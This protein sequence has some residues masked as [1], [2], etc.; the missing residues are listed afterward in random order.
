MGDLKPPP[1][2]YGA[3]LQG[4]PPGATVGRGLSQMPDPLE[5][6]PAGTGLVRADLTGDKFTTDRVPH[7]R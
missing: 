6:D 4:S 3:T 2:E 1:R 5:L 7:S